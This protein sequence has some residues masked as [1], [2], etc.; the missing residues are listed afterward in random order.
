[1]GAGALMVAVAADFA[2]KKKEFRDVSLAGAFIAPWPAILGVL[3]LVVDLGNPQRFWEMILKRGDGYLTLESPFVMFAPSSVMSWGT[4]VLSLFI[5]FSLAYLVAHVAS[6]AL[7]W[8]APIRKFIGACAFVFALPVTVYT[9]V[10]IASCNNGLWNSMWL[11]TLFVVSAI[12]TGIASV[13][14]LLAAFKIFL[15]M[16]PQEPNI[17]KLEKAN[18]VIL[19][20]QLVVL[21]IFLIAQISAPTTKA[22]IGS[23]FGILFWIG[24]VG[25]GLL[26]PILVG[27]KGKALKPQVSFLIAALVMLGG[28]FMRYVILVAGQTIG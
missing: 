2:S 11:P 26:L 14:F 6:F 18:S 4:W 17:P 8:V 22:M 27:L 19:I 10:L 3:L 24:I 7:H 13:V 28:F 25:L 16:E 5:I 12:A 20:V 9:G 23:Q 21:V 1:M 15:N